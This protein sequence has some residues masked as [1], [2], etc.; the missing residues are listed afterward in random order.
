MEGI[1]L[2]KQRG[3]YRGRK[4]SLS[5]EQVRDLVDRAAAGEAKTLLAKEFGISRETVYTYI[6]ASTPAMTGLGRSSQA[7]LPSPEQ[8][9]ESGLRL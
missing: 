4:K 5:R 7:R 2:A 9:R 1:A 3:V 8:P 6:R